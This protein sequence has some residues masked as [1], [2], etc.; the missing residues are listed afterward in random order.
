MSNRVSP[1]YRR[2]DPQPDLVFKN[3][4]RCLNETDPKM[5][6]WRHNLT[7]KGFYSLYPD[8]SSHP[9]AIYECECGRLNYETQLVEAGPHGFNNAN[10]QWRQTLTSIRKE[11]SDE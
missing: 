3:V 2:I 7:F 8:R 4:P 1:N 5:K 9:I 11:L 6:T 10:A